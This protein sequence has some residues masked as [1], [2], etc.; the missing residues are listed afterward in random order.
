MRKVQTDNQTRKAQAAAW[1]FFMFVSGLFFFSV[2]GFSE[3]TVKKGLV[4]EEMSATE[5]K[6]M[7]QELLSEG[8]KLVERKDYNQANATY[9]TV[10]LIQ[11]GNMDAS[12]RIDHLKKIM[13]KEGVSETQ[14]V[15]RIYDQE[16]DVRVGQYLSRAKEF[17]K[18]G[19]LAQARFNLQKLLLINPL[20][21]EANKLYKRV[22]EQL[23]QAA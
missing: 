22:N 21:V 11:P 2:N 23:K 4:I 20:H 7:I 10:F 15:T 12:K 1:V 18:Q 19:K 16:I 13:M 5:K 14:L 6:S 9:E 17:I 3:T 8:D